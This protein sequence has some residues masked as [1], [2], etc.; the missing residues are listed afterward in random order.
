MGA[1]AIAGSRC[2]Y[3]KRAGKWGGSSAAHLAPGGIESAAA[4]AATRAVEGE[5]RVLR[6]AV[7]QACESRVELQLREC[8][9]PR[10]TD[11]AAV[12]ADQRIHAGMP[13]LPPKKRMRNLRLHDCTATL[14]SRG[15]PNSQKNTNQVVKRTWLREVT[16]TTS[17]GRGSR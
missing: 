9:D 1:T 2:C 4:T 14:N 16:S 13:T 5:R 11:A 7:T 3:G 12:G 17:V 10:W 6:A 8:H 15:I